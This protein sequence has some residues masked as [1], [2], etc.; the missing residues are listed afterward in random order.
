MIFFRLSV[1]CI[2]LVFLSVRSNAIE[3]DFRGQLSLQGM[4]MN[5]SNSWDGNAGLQYIPQLTLTQ[6]RP[7]SH[8][9]DIEMSLHGFLQTG[10][11]IS[12]D[13]FTLYRLNARYATT[14]S[15]IQL[16]L[17]KINFGPAQLLRSLMWFDRLNPTD[18]LRV[19]EGVW[20]LRYRY[21]FLNNAN[22]WLWGLHGNEDPKGYEL[23]GSVKDKPEFGGRFQTPVPMGE[24]ALT[25]HTRTVN[26]MLQD[27]REIRYAL[28]GRWDV[29]V[30][31]WFEA[32][33][34]HQ[35][36]GSPFNYT[37]MLTLGLDYTIGIGNGLYV[38]AEHMVN[39][40][41]NELVGFEQ[42]TQ[43]SA[44]MLSYP[45]GMFDSFSLMAFYS[46]KTHDALQ[47]VSWQRSY[48]KIVINLALFHYPD[49]GI[50]MINSAGGGFGAQLM[51]IYNH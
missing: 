40:F 21:N 30:G 48:D 17:Q 23:Y 28:D 51:L 41:S 8:L 4:G 27:F 42:D 18:P 31:A 3:K 11:K 44:L 15:E 43:F 47:Y 26:N 45:L 49:T 1:L 19:T 22:V 37:K 38:L 33:V 10:E 36:I 39:R 14:Q 24:M 16:G 9:F 34:Q 7:N 5:L 32:V 50:S 13:N 29:L 25:L 6:T 46:W 35:E 2:G 20:G 12:K